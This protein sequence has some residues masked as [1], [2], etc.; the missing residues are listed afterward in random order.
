MQGK[1]K[2]VDKT[3]ILQSLEDTDESFWLDMEIEKLTEKR[4]KDIYAELC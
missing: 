3:E 4:Y 2:D 1:K